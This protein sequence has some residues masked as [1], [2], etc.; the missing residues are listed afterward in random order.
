M[1]N[2]IY[3]DKYSPRLPENWEKFKTWAADMKFLPEEIADASSFEE[4][5]MTIARLKEENESE[6]EYF[7]NLY[8]LLQA[9]EQLYINMCQIDDK[10]RTL[11]RKMSN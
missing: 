5:E 9:V 7:E 10:M 11:T 4:A 8:Q 3:K 1:I 2:E 6:K